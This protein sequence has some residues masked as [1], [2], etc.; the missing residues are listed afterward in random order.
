MGSTLAH[1]TALITGG[2]SG[3]G[4]DSARLF[5]TEGAKVIL[6]GHN[7]E[8]LRAAAESIGPAASIIAADLSHDTGA[9]TLAD[10]LAERGDRLDI[11]FA[12]AGTSNAPELFDT[13]EKSFDTVVDANLK[14]TFFTVL[15]CFPHLSDGASVILTSSVSADRGLIG[16]PLYAATKAAVRTLGRGFAGHP[17]FLA[18]NIRVNTLSFGAVATPM[19]GADNP[20]LADALDQWAQT[21]IPIKRWADPIEAAQPALFLASHASSYMTGAD[22]QIDGGLAQL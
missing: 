20:D 1:Q 7:P 6:V 12:N 3:I 19:T 14:T 22:L 15:R 4:L 11:L 18:R 5:A 10:T 21:N 9:H 17:D 2:S 8:R 16:D 13:D